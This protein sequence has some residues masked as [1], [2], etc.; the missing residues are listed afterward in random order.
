MTG[1]LT[2]NSS[3]SGAGEGCMNLLKTLG[4]EEILEVLSEGFCWQCYPLLEARIRRILNR[5]VREIPKWNEGIE[6]SD[7]FYRRTPHKRMRTLESPPQTPEHSYLSRRKRFTSNF[8]GE[9]VTDNR[10]SFEHSDLKILLKDGLG[11]VSSGFD[12]GLS[13]E[14]NEQIR[15]SQVIRKKDFEY[16]ERIDGGRQINVLGGLELH[17]RVFNTKE[18]ENIVEYVYLLQSMGQRGKLRE[19]TYSEP[20]KWMRGKGRVTIQFGCCYNY[21]KDQNGKPPGII[22]DEEVDPIPS[23]FK[24]VIKRMVRWQIL[25]PTCIPNSCIVNIYEEGDCIPPHIDHHDFVRPFCTLSLLSECN[26]VFGSNLKVVGPGE[27]FGPV[28]IPLPVGSVFILNGNGADIA[29][30]CVPGVPT[31]RISITFRKMDESKLPYT[32]LPDPELVGIKPLICSP[33]NT[34]RIQIQHDLDEQLIEKDEFHPQDNLNAHNRSSER[35][36]RETIR[37]RR[38]HHERPYEGSRHVISR[39]HLRLPETSSRE[40]IRELPIPR[41]NVRPETIHG[42]PKPRRKLLPKQLSH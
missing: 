10:N 30:H 4:R 20:R 17:T 11:K 7:S 9:S 8:S 25:P 22:R 31:K 15:I 3:D 41:R 40:T 6:G 16:T 33:L 18:Q 23:L 24:K 38:W 28:S 36:V 2:E 5:K 1:E 29:K 42:F 14:K 32:F 13:E 34:P 39:D 19:R 37:G 26:I 35:L 12:N 27:F 21:A